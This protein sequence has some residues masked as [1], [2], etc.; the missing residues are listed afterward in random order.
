[1]HFGRNGYFHFGREHRVVAALD[2]LRGY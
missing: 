2:A 1:V